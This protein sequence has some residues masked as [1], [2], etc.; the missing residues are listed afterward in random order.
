MKKFLVMAVTALMVTLSANAQNEDLHN[1]LSL[2]YGFG[3]IAQ[4]G[5]GIGEGIGLIF[6]NDEYD[7]GFILGPI[8]AEYYYHFNNPKWAVGGV[9]SYS[10]WD[11]DRIDKS[12]R[13]KISEVNRSFFSVMPSV[14]RYWVNKNKFG[15]YSKVAA[16]IGFLSRT[17][18]K[19]ENGEK[20]DKNG[21]YFMFQLSAIG[22]EF[23][24]QFR[25]FAEAGVGDQGMLI[26][27]VRYK[28]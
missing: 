27:G 16:G 4:L 25:G 7:D 13:E 12:S 6:T 28:F 2:S 22:V 24:S 5:A 9:L 1:E 17:E 8:S 10:K 18:K 14:K 20:K 3:S 21:S 11:S 15:L 26:A 23:G 19:M